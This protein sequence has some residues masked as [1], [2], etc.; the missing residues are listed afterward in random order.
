VR[1]SS[2]DG[3]R[4]PG[5]CPPLTTKSQVKPPPLTRDAFLNEAEEW[6]R[7][8]DVGTTRERGVTGKENSKEVLKEGR[9]DRMAEIVKEAQERGQELNPGGDKLYVRE[10]VGFF[11]GGKGGGG[12]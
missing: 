1:V 6:E 7:V 3:T 5:G 4:L 11:G 9:V 8:V 12:I 10:K 2:R